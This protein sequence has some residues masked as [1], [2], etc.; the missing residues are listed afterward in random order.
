MDSGDPL[1]F[2]RKEPIPRLFAPI[3]VAEDKA[4]RNSASHCRNGRLIRQPRRFPQIFVLE[5]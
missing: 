1:S 4:L 3:T 2:M 5:G